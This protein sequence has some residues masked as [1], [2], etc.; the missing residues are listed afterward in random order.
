[1]RAIPA[2]TIVIV[3]ASLILASFMASGGAAAQTGCGI[4]LLTSNTVQGSWTSDCTSQYRQDSY[5]RSYSLR[6]TEP[7]EVTITLESE[8]DPY[9]FLHSEQGDFIDEND[10]I[11]LDVRNYNS[12]II[13]SLS[14]GSYT[15]EATTY[16][17]RVTGD[18][19]LTVTGV[20]F[21]ASDDNDRA[22]LTALYHAT[23]GDNWRRND[24]WLTNAPLDE[25]YGVET[26]GKRWIHNLS[27][28]DNQLTGQLPLELGGLY[29]PKGLDFGNNQL[30]GPIPSQLG[31]LNLALLNLSNNK[32]TGTI[33]SELSRMTNL[34]ELDL[35][36]NR[37]EGTIP[38]TLGNLTNLTFL[39]LPDNLLIGT[40]P[41]ELG[42]LTHLEVLSLEYN[43]LWGE[44]PRNLTAL[45]HLRSFEYFE[46]AGLCLPDDAAF[47][48]WM[49]SVSDDVDISI[50]IPLS[51]TPDARD[52]EVL[53]TLY[54]T[55]NGDNWRD[56]TNWFSEQPLQYWKGVTINS[57]GRVIILDL[58][59]NDLSGHIP[60]E[61]GDLDALEELTLGSQL[62]GAIPSE[63]GN[64]T[65]LELLDLSNNELTGA[66]PLKLS[67]LTNLKY[68]ELFNNHLTG[69]IPP[70]LG[71]LSMLDSLRLDG[72]QLAGTIPSELAK[73]INLTDLSLNENELTGSIPPE[74]SNL[75][76]LMYL[77]LDDNQLTGD[78]PSALGN[79]DGLRWLL[80]DHNQLTGTIPP[81]IGNLT[82][83]R[84]VRFAGNQL[85]GCVPA[86]LREVNSNDFD[87]LGLPFCEDAQP[88]T[89]MP[90]NPIPEGCTLQ[91]IVGSDSTIDDA[92][93]SDC[94]SQ[95]RMEN[96]EH[97]A[98]F[99]GFTVDRT[100]SIDITLVSRTDTYMFLLDEYGMVVEENDNYDHNIFDLHP[101]SSGIR[102]TLDPGNYI[103]EATTYANEA[104][105]DFTLTI[106]SPDITA[107]RA[108]YHSTNGAD[109]TN[110]DNWLTDAP[111]SEW[112]GVTTDDE[113]SVTEIY[114]IGNNLVGTIPAE[115]GGMY[116]LEGLYLARNQLS[117][118]IP[119]ELGNLHNLETLMLF[120][121][122]L[123]GAIP[124]ELGSLASLKE[125]HLGRN[126]LSGAI[127][128]TLGNL[129]NLTRLHMTVNELSGVIPASLGNLTELRQLSIASNNLSGPIPT[130]IADLS[131]LTHIYLWDN[132]LLAGRFVNSLDRMT[133]LR[134]LDIGGN[135]IDGEDVLAE[136]YALH[137]LTGLG[138]HNS[139]ITDDHMSAY[140]DDLQA[141]DLEFLNL[142]ENNLSDLQTLVDLSEIETIQRLVIHS[143]DL[144]GELPRTMTRLTLMRLFYFH[145]NA[146]L[147]A[148]TDD[149]FQ[150]WLRGIRDVLGDICTDGS[151]TDAPAQQSSGGEYAAMMS[152]SGEAEDN[153]SLLSR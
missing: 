71:D 138:I 26:D 148:P 80:L 53:T 111:L 49:Q 40:I 31:N 124:S 4:Q 121:N 125:L 77:S 94:V 20:D 73:L 102:I 64:L 47:Q 66:I 110:N 29:N 95:N 44:L 149:E 131:N 127:P 36:S 50:C 78:I 25:W 151:P 112:H 38:P 120:R 41:P 93:T 33:P 1:M 23:D 28:N 136:L 88:P 150:D 32:L 76:A 42:S 132:N 82:D 126:Q 12:R 65:R 145:A 123:S 46:N 140:M 146:G 99:F 57:D 24:N 63:L 108:L 96:G 114:L 56:N 59:S 143:N 58:D 34:V 147:C 152:I 90:G 83:L 101:R 116:N 51:T 105:G 92:W 109:W 129:Q 30:T 122:E 85:T 8:A 153:H 60:A 79:L 68:L 86:A 55:T 52:V 39:Y 91:S 10:D 72:N 17:E 144:S 45:T 22:A 11:D 135:N 106:A 115:L 117:G 69:H 137:N 27:L 84:Y 139:Y 67:N 16:L 43:R 107:L 9:L 89:P 6:L 48:E 74:L 2:S 128:V 130:E 100:S 118:A 7:A 5:A 19:T 37:L 54:N 104:T 21:S 87:E 61:L 113:G 35:H 75:A 141:L 119:P 134:F 3:F 62:R 15:I 97:Y 14:A 81:E 13:A 133:E 18:F 142:S 70:E 103:V 98:K